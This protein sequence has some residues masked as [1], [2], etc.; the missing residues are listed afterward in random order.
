MLRW[1]AI[2]L[3]AAASLSA[4]RIKLYMTDGDYHLVREYEVTGDRVRF[5]TLERSQWEEMPLELIDLERTQKEIE[6]KKEAQLKEEAFWDAEE[7]AE[8]ARRREIARIPAT[9][10]VY[11][12]ENDEVHR[13]PRADLQSKT[14]KKKEVLKVISPVPM[15]A[16]ERNL[17]IA[18][19]HAETVFP[20]LTPT[21][22]IRLFHEERFG[23]IKLTPEAKK[24]RRHVEEWAVLPVTNQVIEKHE[25]VTVFRR[26]VGENLYQVWPKAP[27]EP[28]EYAVV[29]FS[30][31]E[32]NIVV[33]DF[34]CWPS[35][36]PPPSSER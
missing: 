18:G 32:A 10:G 35:G 5:Y 14:N 30:A 12:V 36:S 34:G 27:L 16:G 9:P 33:W 26:Q 6:G 20:T 13:L 4:A 7:E 11:W 31:G 23:F 17:Y 2:L 21:F 8:R 24:Q 19:A 22:Y 15:I 3:L 29:E 28:G 25:E 1:V